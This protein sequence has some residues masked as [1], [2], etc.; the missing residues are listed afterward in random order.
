LACFILKSFDKS[1]SLTIASQLVMDLF[2]LKSNNKCQT[3]S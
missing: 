2:L 1:L 3:H